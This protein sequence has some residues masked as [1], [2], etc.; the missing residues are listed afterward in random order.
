MSGLALSSWSICF[1]SLFRKAQLSGITVVMT[2]IILAIILQ[3]VPPTSTGA[4]TV[5]SL[6]FPPMNFVLFIIYA[7]Y[8]QQ[9]GRAIEL[10]QGPPT[11]PW[12]T[13]GYVFFLFCA[14]QISVFPIIGAFIERTLYG[15]ASQARRLRYD[16]TNSMEA[17]RISQV[18]K[19]GR[20]CPF[21]SFLSGLDVLLPLF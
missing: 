1:A 8:W 20:A 12:S 10:S 15:T 11:S 18:R 4:A 3:V 9:Q 6:L 7:A 14:I 5:L 21:S 19:S 2:S 16:E 13:P 17:M